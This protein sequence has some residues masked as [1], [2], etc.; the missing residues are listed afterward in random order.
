MSGGRSVHGGQVRLLLGS[1]RSAPASAGRGSQK[2]SDVTW[3]GALKDPG[4]PDLSRSSL[5]QPAP[6]GIIGRY[7]KPPSQVDMDTPL[8]RN[9]N[10]FPVKFIEVLFGTRLLLCFVTVWLY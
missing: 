6:A 7:F 9:H 2:V 8:Q 1:G 4:G 5:P 10:K 3:R